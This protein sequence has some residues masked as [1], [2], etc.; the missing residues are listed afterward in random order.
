MTVKIGIF[1]YFFYFC[2][3]LSNLGTTLNFKFQTFSY[4]IGTKYYAS[5]FH[6][7]LHA[8][9]GVDWLVVIAVR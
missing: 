5:P 7:A 4:N 1:S 3:L 6:F 2:R 9:H 8:G